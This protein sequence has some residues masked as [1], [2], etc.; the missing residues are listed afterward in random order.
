MTG[1]IQT[2]LEGKIDIVIFSNKDKRTDK[3]PDFRVY[4]SEKKKE[5][6][7]AS[8]KTEAKNKTQ[9]REETSSDEVDVL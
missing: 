9:S 7:I 1:H 6:V 4:L 8:P 2:S 3:A 5:D